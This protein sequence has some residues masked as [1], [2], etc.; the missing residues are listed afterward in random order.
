[1]LSA[2]SPALAVQDLRGVGTV[3]PRPGPITADTSACGRNVAVAAGRHAARTLV[4]LQ[5]AICGVPRFLATIPFETALPEV[6]LG[7]VGP[8]RQE[9]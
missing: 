3:E 7:K 5:T 1:M 8:I 9:Q 4:G 2:V 6:A